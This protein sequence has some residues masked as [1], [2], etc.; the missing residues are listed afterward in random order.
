MAEI[1]EKS[2]ASVVVVHKINESGN[3]VG[4]GSGYV[5]SDDGVVITNYH[6][7]RG[8]NGLIVQKTSGSEVRVDSVLV[9]VRSDLDP[10][11]CGSS[12]GALEPCPSELNP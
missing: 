11:D 9:R 12:W 8:A 2:L 5:Y 7:I 6:V 1:A 3:K 4:H 10:V